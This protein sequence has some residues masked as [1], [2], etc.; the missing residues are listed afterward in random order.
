MM[1]FIA[2]LKD[3][4]R[5]AVDG[6]VIYVMLAL[7]A[8][9]IIIV[10]SMSYTPAAP[11]EAF[12][13]IVKNFNL[14]FP[15]KGR[16]RV[17]TGSSN[18]YIASDVQAAGGGYQLRLTVIAMGKMTTGDVKGQQVPERSQGDTFRE[19]VA[20]WAKPA[21]KVGEAEVGDAKGKGEKK[22]GGRKVEFGVQSAT[23]EEQKA[24]TDERMEE[25]L[26]SQ[27]TMHAGMDSTVKRV[28]SGVDEPS[29]AFEV[30]TTGGSSVRGWP[31]TLKIFF[32]SVTISRDA[33]LGAVLF[34]IE[35]QIINGVGSGLALLISL[36]ITSFFIP[37]MLR[38]GSI[39]L[40]VSKPI[41]RSQLLIY[42]YVGGLTFIFLLSTITIGGVWLA[43][44][45]RSGHWDPTFLVVIPILTFTFAILYAVSTLVAVF[46]RSPIA[47]MLISLGFAVFLYIVGFIKTIFDRQKIE[48]SDNIPE[49]AY[50]LVDTI[51]N[52]LPRYK[53]L[54]KL[55]SKLIG[56]GTLTP[57]ESRMFGIAQIDYPS[58][59]GTFG[60]SLGFIAIMM[61]LSCWRF[62]KRD[63]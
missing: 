32:G 1:R 12:D 11:P 38:K 35:D 46:T 48:G 8:L 31:H 21:N 13:S 52:V 3:S 14:V 25:F 9:M 22:K 15:D 54:D 27:F 58:W 26:K 56:E 23:A 17:F 50:T 63:Y 33:P 61:A 10:G 28:K 44:A 34:L 30:T 59:G 6:F 37:N 39:D 20:G 57:G 36:I 51:N 18:N 2:I 47:A 4:F 40:L 45:V 60:V 42:K 7:S 41:G 19:A 43:I 53:D 62:S 16:S 49:W 55:T 5:E 29:Y 24:V